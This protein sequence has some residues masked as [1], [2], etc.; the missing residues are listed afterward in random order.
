MLCEFGEVLTRHDADL[1]H[2]RH[3]GQEHVSGKVIDGTQI[4]AR[5]SGDENDIS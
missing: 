4:R 5:I 2:M 1:V 3:P